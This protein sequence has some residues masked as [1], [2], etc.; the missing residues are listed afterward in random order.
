MEIDIEG[1]KVV[2]VNGAR[3]CEL[4]IVTTRPI[5]RGYAILLVPAGVPDG[6]FWLRLER[7]SDETIRVSDASG[8]PGTWHRVAPG[9]TTPKKL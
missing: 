8:S 2:M 6:R 3:S 7:L 5:Q 9:G 4:G 1:R